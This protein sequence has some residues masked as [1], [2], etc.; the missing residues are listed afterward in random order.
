[1]FGPLAML[2]VAGLAEQRE[3]RWRIVRVGTQQ[4][5]QTARLV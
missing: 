4:A 2:E 5:A 1:M 3:G